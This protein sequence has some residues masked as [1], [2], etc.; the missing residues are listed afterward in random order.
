MSGQIVLFDIPS[1]EP[2][3]CWSLNP[4]KTRILL[5][6]KGLDYRTEWLEYPD[7][8]PRL[9][10]H[11]PPNEGNMKY[12]IPTIQLPSGEYITDSAKIADAIEAAHPSPPV[13]LDSPILPKIYDIA[14]RVRT[15]ILG[16][17]ATGVPEYILA[18]ASKPYWYET[19][20]KFIGKPVE[21]LKAEMDVDAAW[22][23]AGATVQE[24]TT[25]LK[26]NGDGP[27]FL[28]KEIS[29]AD[30]VWAGFLL[31]SKRARPGL[32]DDILARSGDAEAHLALLK[33]LEPWTERDGH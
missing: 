23:E 8:R 29:Y 4:W 33:A 26:E 12:T 14:A 30:F 5:N 10:P 31:F 13:H 21:Q 9:E 32:L 17:Y 15:P 20:A 7:I 24:A 18:E 11:L 1:R 3:T 22:A 27:F 25:L 19:R 2:R 28:G 6:Y 16:L